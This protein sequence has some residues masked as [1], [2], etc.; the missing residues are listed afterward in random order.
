MP[1]VLKVALAQ[2]APAWLDR[3]ATLQK[4]EDRVADAAAKGA[5]MVVFGEALLPGYP[6]WPELT[7]G[8][9]F[10]SDIQKDLYAHY[11]DHAVDLARGDLAELCRLAGQ[12]GIGIYLGAIE[13][14]ADPSSMLTGQQI[15]IALYI[16]VHCLEKLVNVPFLLYRTPTTC[17]APAC[18]GTI[19]QRGR[20]PVGRD[21]RTTGARRAVAAMEGCDPEP[22]RIFGPRRRH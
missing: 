19:R 18:H 17:S 10:E 22:D 12:K 1:G 11:V 15:P 20:G 3:P 7:D 2:I 13:R 6:F 14:S 8:A 9:R 4:I 21:E 16:S 5:G